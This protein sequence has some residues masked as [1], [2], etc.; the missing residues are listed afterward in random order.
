MS[1]TELAF[2][3]ILVYLGCCVG[4]VVPEECEYNSR[5]G[6]HIGEGEEE[7]GHQQGEVRYGQLGVIAPPTSVT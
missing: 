5:E 3:F 4:G 2:A 1:Q 6:S 7:G